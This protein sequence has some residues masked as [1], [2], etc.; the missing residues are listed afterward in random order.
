MA[1][2]SKNKF[3]NLSRGDLL[4]SCLEMEDELERL[5]PKPAKFKLGQIVVSP[6]KSPYGGAQPCFAFTILS[7][8]QRNGKWHYGWD[9]HSVHGFRVFPEEKLRALTPTEIDGSAQATVTAAVVEAP[10]AGII[11]PLV[12]DWTGGPGHV[13]HIPNDPEF[14]DPDF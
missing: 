8:E 5:R 11:Q 2:K 6:G 12:Q 10:P 3:D 14:T 9:K 7:V 1:T 4:R 13:A